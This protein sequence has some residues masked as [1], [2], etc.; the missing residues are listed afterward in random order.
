MCDLRLQ[1]APVCTRV[2]RVLAEISDAIR[3][4]SGSREAAVIA[5][6]VDL[7]HIKQQAERGLYVWESC[8]KLIH[9]IL[10]VVQ[11]VQSRKRDEETKEKWEPIEEGLTM[12]NHNADG[13]PRAFCKGLEFLLDRV[14]ALRIDAA[15]ARLRLIAPVIK[16]HGVDYERG[17]FQ[18]QLNSGTITLERTQQWIKHAVRIEVLEKRV[19]L[20]RLLDGK[21]DAF[22][23]V[24]TKA[25][26]N[27]VTERTTMKAD[28][29]PEML[30]LDAHRIAVLQREFGT[31]TATVPL[32]CTMCCAR[33]QRRIAWCGARSRTCWCRRSART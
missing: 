26:L 19:D 1:P 8:T 14:N 2:L 33:T 6:L 10:A 16:D 32:L 25:V 9:G 12:G 21:A 13:R 28:A 20:D 17:R 22:V 30:L 29:C 24:H 7:D 31:L 18:N 23:H 27:L 15:N 3:D 5:E 11:R 4:V